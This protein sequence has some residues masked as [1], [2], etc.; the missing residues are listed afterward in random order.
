MKNILTLLAFGLIALAAAQDPP[1]KV[2]T[3]VFCNPAPPLIDGLGDDSVWEE[4]ETGTGFTQNEPHNGEPATET[5]TFKIVYDA[6]NL[7][8]LIRNHDRQAHKIISRLTRRD[9]DEEVDEAGIVLDSY[10]DRRTGFGFGVT[11]AGVKQDLI[12]SN[13]GENEDNSWDPVWYAKTTIDDSGWTAEMRIPFSQLRFA[14]KPQQIWGLEIYRE[15]PRNAELALWQ[16]IPKDA[17]G[18][19]HF[20]GELHGLK[21]L[22]HPKRIEL[23]P[24][25]VADLST[26]RPQPDNPFAPGRSGHFKGGLDGKI[27]V[28]SDLTMDFTINPDFGQ[29]EADPS[30]V[31][32]TAFETFF[33][34]KRPFFIEGKNIFNYRLTPGD[35]DLSMDQIFYSRRIGRTPHREVETADDEYAKAPAHT[36]ILGAFKLSGK[37]RHGVSI[38]VLDAV[39]QHERAEIRR[40]DETRQESI[41][42]L[43]NYFV[44][45]LQKDYGAGATSVGMILTGTNRRIADANLNFLNRAAY[46]GGIDCRHAWH[47]QN[48]MVDVRTACSHIRGHRDALLEAQTASARYFQRPDANH[49]EV[50]SAR[51]TLSGSGGSVNIGKVGGGH[52]RFLLG[53]IWRTPGLELND[54][55][56]MRQADQKIQVFWGQYRTLKPH[57][58]FREVYANVNQWHF[59]NFG[60]DFIGRGANINTSVTFTNSW[61]INGGISR[62]GRWLVVAALR[63]G[64]ALYNPPGSNIWYQFSSDARRKVSFYG[65]GRRYRNDDGISTFKRWFLGVEMRPTAAFSLSVNPSLTLCT[66]DLQYVDTIATARGPRY[67][68]GRIDQKNLALVMRFDYCLTP[69]LSI[70][71]Y[72]QPFVAAGQ[73]T[74]FKSITKPRAS[75]Y[76]DQF[77]TFADDQM[78]WDEENSQYVID[79]DRDGQEEYRFDKPD[80]NF[81]QFRSNLVL[82]WEYTAGST[83][84]LVWSQGR[85]GVIEEGRF[86]Y[87]HDLRDLFNVYPE[88]VFLVKCNYWFSL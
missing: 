8:V 29:V 67:L 52:W 35:G 16:H 71:Y 39:T 25:S 2:Y 34:E 60:G 73:Y 32:L 63:G 77:E 85:T 54:I 74:R 86:S 55:G 30:E 78:Q 87:R 33:A 51:T 3:A 57:G 43:S 1:K 7:Y 84:F 19:V 80:Y 50:D 76:S 42:P 68:M 45:R 24:Y 65:G 49:V 81:R 75:V 56:Y 44:S 72:G 61:R 40:G 31:N 23:L 18:I 9:G 66:D 48:W 88:N 82:R 27:G 83:F 6:E 46:T 21:N 5:T 14:D 70:Q 26:S 13:D 62:E 69:N 37:T 20:F 4:A 28:T 41:E 38:G 22:A 15:M 10:F 59:G 36:S 58:I 12:F 53:W 17:S 79:E 11:A 64:P 47:Q